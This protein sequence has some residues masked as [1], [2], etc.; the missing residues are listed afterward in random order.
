[1]MDI[2]Q[3]IFPSVVGQAFALLPYNGFLESPGNLTEVTMH[4]PT[5]AC[6]STFDLGPLMP[7]GALATRVSFF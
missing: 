6:G 7:S 4:V 1:M 2:L 3:E 5:T